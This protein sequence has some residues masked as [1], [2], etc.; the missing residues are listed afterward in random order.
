[1]LME[2]SYTVQE[3]IVPS[4]DHTKGA[5]DQEAFV[6]VAF[7]LSYDIAQLVGVCC[8]LFPR[9]LSSRRARHFEDC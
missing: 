3:L 8:S 7:D 9:A 5:N 1:M 6:E 4:N 2:G